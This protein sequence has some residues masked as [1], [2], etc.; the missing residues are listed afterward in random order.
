[1]K[2]LIILFTTLLLS[3]ILNAQVKELPEQSDTATIQNSSQKYM[4]KAPVEQYNYSTKIMYSP[5]QFER[6]KEV[7]ILI[8]QKKTELQNA[9]DEIQRL[10]LERDIRNLEEELST[11]PKPIIRE[12]N[13]QTD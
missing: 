4:K 7:S 2:A 8:E 6:A 9:T 1:M 12:Q 13:S 10:V 5:K 3:Q 11:L